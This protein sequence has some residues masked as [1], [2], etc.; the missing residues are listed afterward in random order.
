MTHLTQQTIRINK[1]KYNATTLTPAI[2][3][4]VIT[5][6]DTLI[7]LFSQRY[8]PAPPD[9]PCNGKSTPEEK[10]LGFCNT[11]QAELQGQIIGHKT[12]R[13]GDSLEA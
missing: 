2:H 11:P 10:E 1:G 4:H 9:Q 8:L 13:T 3:H 5:S 12:E 6:A 7:D